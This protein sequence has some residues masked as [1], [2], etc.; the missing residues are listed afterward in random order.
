MALQQISTI[1]QEAL[2]GRFLICLQVRVPALQWRPGAL[3][4]Q[5]LF[6]QH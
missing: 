1:A 6:H 5:Q 3:S 4:L 2:L